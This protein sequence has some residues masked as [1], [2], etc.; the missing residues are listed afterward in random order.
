MVVAATPRPH[1]ANEDGEELGIDG[2][3]PMLA[4]G[5]AAGRSVACL[6]SGPARSARERGLSS[7]AFPGS[8]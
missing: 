1:P 2:H 3:A 7:P 8:A 4:G 5:A 6:F